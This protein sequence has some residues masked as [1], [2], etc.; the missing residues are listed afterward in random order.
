MAGDKLTFKEILTETK[1]FSK[2]S[3]RKIDMYKKM[4]TDE[5]RKILND[6]KEGKELDIQLYKSENFKSNNE[7][8]ESKANKKLNGQ[9]IK[10]ATDVTSYAYQKQN[11]R[12]SLLKVYNGIGSFTT[13]L[14][15]QA[16]FVFYDTQ[17]KQNFV[18]IAQKDE[19]IKQ[20]D[21]IIKQNDE[22]IKLL[23][24]IA[25]NNQSI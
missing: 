8:Y 12:P 6:F 7:E 11:I 23:K 19:L 20:N 16:K 24:Q 21:K 1:M 10:E 3:N 4:T 22:I 17:L 14:D 15:K 5:K 18:F 25:D 2:L 13:N 9:G